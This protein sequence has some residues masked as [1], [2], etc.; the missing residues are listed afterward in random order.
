MPQIE[1]GE[2]MTEHMKGR[3]AM[4][5][6]TSMQC[7]YNNNYKQQMQQQSTTPLSLAKA[8]PLDPVLW[9]QGGVHVTGTIWCCGSISRV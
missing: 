8:T 1:L 9:I 5:D 3:A 7:M 6:M 2:L 4:S